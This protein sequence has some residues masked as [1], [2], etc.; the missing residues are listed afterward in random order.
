[1]NE[2]MQERRVRLVIL[3]QHGLLRASLGRLLASEPDLEMA[4]ECGTS[5]E[6][7]E[8]LKSSAVDVILLDFEIGEEHGSDFIPAATE[9][10][11]SG[12]FLILAGSADVRNAAIAL[13]LSA[14]GIF[15]KSEPPDRLV[16]A[17]RR[18]RDGGIWVDQKIIRSS[19]INRL[20]RSLTLT[21]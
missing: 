10:G 13:K 11:Y 15:L 18:V 7:L 8:V 6:A 14:S 19:P 21:I 5:A 2:E 20:I 9:A 1:M 4:G 12:R 16:Q 3:D 17:I